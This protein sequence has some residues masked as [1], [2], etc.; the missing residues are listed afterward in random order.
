M[1]LKKYSKIHLAYLIVVCIL[2]QTLSISTIQ[3]IIPLELSEEE[4]KETYNAFVLNHQKSYS[5]VSENIKVIADNIFSAET[6]E[7]VDDLIAS[8]ANIFKMI[9]E[10][11]I[12][13]KETE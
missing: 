13:K 10:I 1:N 7:R 2:K 12:G 3:N 5:Y 4:V 6:P 9:S 8:S 11:I